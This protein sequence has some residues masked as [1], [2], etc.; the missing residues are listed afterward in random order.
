MA[1]AG[2][3]GARRRTPWPWN[4]AAASA[5]AGRIA[6]KGKAGA[7]RGDKE[8]CARQLG[9]HPLGHRGDIQWRERMRPKRPLCCTGGITQ[10][11]LPH[12]PLRLLVLFARPFL[13]RSRGPPACWVAPPR[14]ITGYERFPPACRGHCRSF[15]TPRSGRR[16]R[17]P[18]RAGALAPSGS[19]AMRYAGGASSGRGA[20]GRGRHA[21]ARARRP[22]CAR[23]G[24]RRHRSCRHCITP[25]LPRRCSCAAGDRVLFAW[26]AHSLALFMLACT[27]FFCMQTVKGCRK[28]GPC[29]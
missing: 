7:A 24:K 4:D 13:R 20:L 9:G 10:S 3:A 2:P 21:R 15:A 12:A 25:A 8:L 11:P 1:A 28:C 29:T 14:R 27:L 26:L 16:R 6:G 22:D 18:I 19:A 23:C 17:M 5:E